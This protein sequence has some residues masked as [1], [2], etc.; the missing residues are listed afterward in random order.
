MRRA[1]K[2]DLLG[3]AAAVEPRALARE[4]GPVVTETVVVQTNEGNVVGHDGE[5]R[6]GGEAQN[7]RCDA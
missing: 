4:P 2:P 3:V 6:V 5:G 7:A 1:G